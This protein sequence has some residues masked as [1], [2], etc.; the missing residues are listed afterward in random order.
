[1]YFSQGKDWWTVRRVLSQKMLKPKQVTAFQGELNEVLDDVVTRLRH[2]RDTEG[3]N[4]L[5][6]SLPNELYKWAFEC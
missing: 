4:A 1:M 5:V 2:I 6:S 3:E